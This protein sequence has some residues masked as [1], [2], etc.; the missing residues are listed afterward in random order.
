MITVLEIPANTSM[1]LDELRAAL[2]KAEK[3]A[4]QHLRDTLRLEIE[5]YG[6]DYDGY[7]QAELKIT[8]EATPEESAEIAEAKR[9]RTKDTDANRPIFREGDL[10]HGDFI[11]DGL[12][13]SP[14]QADR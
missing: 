14:P 6:D 2:D 10:I 11:C 1:T 12:I 8:R 7:S 9:L 5:Q 4:P 3:Q 13:V